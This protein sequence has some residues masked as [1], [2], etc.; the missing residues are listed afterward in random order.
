MFGNIVV[1]KVACMLMCSGPIAML[2]QMK[3]N[4]IGSIPT[5]MSTYFKVKKFYKQ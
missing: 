5:N 4:S 2:Q 3:M 1:V